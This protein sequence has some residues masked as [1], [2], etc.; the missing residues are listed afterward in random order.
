MSLLLSGQR[1]EIEENQKKNKTTLKDLEVNIKENQEKMKRSLVELEK[2]KQE[3]RKEREA[4]QQAVLELL[5]AL[6]QE[7]DAYLAYAAKQEDKKKDLQASLL[8]LQDLIESGSASKISDELL[9]ISIS[10]E[11]N[12]ISALSPGLKTLLFEK[13]GIHSKKEDLDEKILRREQEITE[14]DN[15]IINLRKDIANSQELHG[16]ESRRREALIGELNTS[17]VQIKNV[18]ERESTYKNQLKGEEA[19]YQF[20]NQQRRNIDQEILAAND[21]IRKTQESIRQ[22]TSGIEKE[23]NQ[24]Q[25]LETKLDKQREKHTALE[26]EL[27]NNQ[28]RIEAEY[29]AINELEIALGTLLAAREAQV[30]DIFNDYNM[31]LDEVRESIGKARIQLATEKE[32][33]SALKQEVHKL[34][35]VNPLAIEE[36][37]EV[38]KLYDHNDQQLTDLRKARGDILAVIEDIEKKSEEQFLKSFGRNRKNFAIVFKKLFKGGDIKL[39]LLEPEKPLE[40]GIDISVQPPGK[41]GALFAFIVR[42]RKSSHRDSADVWNLHG[43]KFAF[44]CAR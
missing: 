27:R 43:S 10:R 25:S 37:I 28:E 21:A 42:R 32:K 41:K 39:K 22:L 5:T 19:N 40:S 38:K 35:P 9:P 36:V 33:L 7:K 3:L 29:S 34:G 16:N 30:Q 26:K 1:Q 2:L 8:K 15:A 17:N 44:L 12:S 18:S 31:T 13:G 14:S 6:K 24:I 11:L 23:V 20:L 4:Q